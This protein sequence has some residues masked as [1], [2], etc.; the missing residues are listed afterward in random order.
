MA[1]G[2]AA[3]IDGAANGADHVDLYAGDHPH[4]DGQH[5]LPLDQVLDFRYTPRTMSAKDMW[6]ER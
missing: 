3:R 5:V 2:R 6:E 4:A 1:V